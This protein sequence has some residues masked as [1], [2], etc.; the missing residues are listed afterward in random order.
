M[1]SGFIKNKIILISMLLL[2]AALHIKISSVVSH[3]DE[4]SFTNGPARA[5]KCITLVTVNQKPNSFSLLNCSPTPGPERKEPGKKKKQNLSLGTFKV[6]AY[7]PCEECSEGY[8]NQTSTGATATEGRTVAVDPDV[9]PYGTRIYIK[10]LGEFT[11]EDCGGDV[12]GKHIDIYFETHEETV[13]FG[14]K[15]KK[16]GMR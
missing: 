1:R 15:Y 11:A 5:A 10:G 8:G 9:I 7:C 14:V 13:E 3:C 12:K 4:S 2:L 16:V 6:T